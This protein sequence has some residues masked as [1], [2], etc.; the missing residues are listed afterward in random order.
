MLMKLIHVISSA[1]LFGGT[2]GVSVFY[3]LAHRRGGVVETAVAGFCRTLGWATLVALLVQPLTGMILIKLMEDNVGSP[4]LVSA[5]V[6]YTLVLAAWAGSMRL[7]TRFANV[8]RPGEASEFTVWA[9]LSWGSVA[10]LCV[11]YYLMLAQPALW[12]AA[13]G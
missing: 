13:K 6:L 9:V 10:V 7:L 1:V 4:W 3:T 5:Y 11:V 8:G 12:S 2:L